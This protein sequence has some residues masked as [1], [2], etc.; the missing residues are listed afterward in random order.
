MPF[1]D[2]IQ[3]GNEGLLKAVDRFEHRRGNKFGTYATWWI[4]QTVTRFLSDQGRTIRLP[5]HLSDR[6]RRVLKVAQRIEQDIGRR[7]TP[8]EI[9]AEMP[10]LDAE[11]ARWLLRVARRSVSLDEPVGDDKD[12]G[13]LVDFIEDETGPSPDQ[14]TESRLLREGLER[15]LTNLAPREARVLRMRFG[16]S[17]A[18]TH[19]LQEVGE[20]IGVTR[21]RVRQIEARALGKLRHPR[22]SRTLRDYLR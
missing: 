15:V 19:T 8:E 3:A 5:I 12:S 7:P 1:L 18:R 16:L 13:E 2:L 4:R 21:E 20:K 6:I 17:G 11:K 14:V 10:E 9:A 22:H